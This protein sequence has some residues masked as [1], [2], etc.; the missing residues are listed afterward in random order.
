MELQAA[1]PRAGSRL[2]PATGRDGGARSCPLEPV[3]QQARQAR[4]DRHRGVRPGGLGQAALLLRRERHRTHGRRRPRVRPMGDGRCGCRY[5]GSAHGG[6]PPRGG[7][8]AAFGCGDLERGELAHPRALPALLRRI[9]RRSRKA[10]RPQ[11][12]RPFLGRVR[13]RRALRSGTRR[14][15]P[16]SRMAA[17]RRQPRGEGTHR[18]GMRRIGDILR[19]PARG[20]KS[21]FGA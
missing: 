1:L 12:H 2:C 5:G 6:L 9:G 15:Q 7:P 16:G 13:R 18:S 21:G 19:H 8:D 14:P 20:G 11:A 3:I 10:L 4:I 17:G